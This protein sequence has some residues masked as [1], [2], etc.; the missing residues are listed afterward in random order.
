[1]LGLIFSA[2]A[3]AA[4]SVELSDDAWPRIPKNGPI[5]DEVSDLIN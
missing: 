3:M 4:D 1:M 5:N 2:G